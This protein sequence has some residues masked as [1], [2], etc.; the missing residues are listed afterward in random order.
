MWQKM[1][2]VRGRFANAIPTDHT[3]IWFDQ[4]KN[5]KNFTFF[6][7]KEAATRAANCLISNIKP[8][9]KDGSTTMM[10]VKSK[11]KRS[12]SEKG[13]LLYNYCTDTEPLYH[14]FMYSLVSLFFPLNSLNARDRLLKWCT[15]CQR[16]IENWQ[17]LGQAYISMVW[18][19]WWK[20]NPSAEKWHVCHSN[21]IFRCLFKATY[22]YGRIIRVH[23]KIIIENA[24][25][26]FNIITNQ[27]LDVF[28][29]SVVW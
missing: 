21:N 9:Y 11:L 13:H 25:T 3:K 7:T 16:K 24:R 6:L 14:S 17:I 22:V 5:S 12:R 18:K 27:G 20:P 19:F 10:C 2:K 23:N 4:T 1:G 8:H 26:L 15:E 29:S 28:L